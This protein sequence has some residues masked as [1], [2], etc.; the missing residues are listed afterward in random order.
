MFSPQG[1]RDASL[2][3][4]REKHRPA[5]VTVQTRPAIFHVGNAQ[6]RRHLRFPFAFEFRS[7]PCLTEDIYRATTMPHVRANVHNIRNSLQDNTLRLLPFFLESAAHVFCTV[8]MQPCVHIGQ[9]L[10]RYKDLRQF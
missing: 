10:T 6:F 1:L 5:A 8:L 4:F 3:C 7:F 2:L 9:E